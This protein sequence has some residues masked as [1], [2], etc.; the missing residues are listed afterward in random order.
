M[1]A[2]VVA[3]FDAHLNGGQLQSLLKRSQSLHGIRVAFHKV[4]Q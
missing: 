3:F 4:D 1:N 2:S